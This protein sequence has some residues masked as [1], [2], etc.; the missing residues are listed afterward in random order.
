M[1][2]IEGSWRYDAAAKQVVVTIRQTQTGDPYRL[3]L[4]VGLTP[5]SGPARVVQMAV[6]DRD[7]TM[8]IPADAEPTSVALD[9]GVWV[10][11]DWGAFTRQG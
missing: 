6:T 8:T 10:L 1:P 9:P 4:G 3:S 7:A 11:A 2:A 5:A